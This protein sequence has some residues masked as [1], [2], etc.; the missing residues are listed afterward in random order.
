MTIY[1]QGQGDKKFH[2]Q[3]SIAPLTVNDENNE[4]Y[5]IFDEET[6]YTDIVNW[7][8]LANGEKTVKYDDKIDGYA[9]LG[10]EVDLIYMINVPEG[11]RGEDIIL[12]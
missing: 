2:Y 9:A 7:T 6:S 8:T 10:E 1:Q 3:A 11:A 12:Q 4:Y 5:G